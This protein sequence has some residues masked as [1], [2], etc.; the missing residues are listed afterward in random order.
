MLDTHTTMY[1]DLQALIMCDI[2]LYTVSQRRLLKA[3]YWLFVCIKR[4]EMY[5][6]LFAVSVVL[7]TTSS[8]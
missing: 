2:H 5:S 6:S 1:S 4:A 3:K 7:D 8:I